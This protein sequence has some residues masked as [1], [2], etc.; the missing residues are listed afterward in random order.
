MDIHSAQLSKGPLH[1]ADIPG[2]LPALVVIHG[3][4]GRPHDFKRLFP[5]IPSQRIIAVALPGMG[6]SPLH[7]P[8]YDI[9]GCASLVGELLEYLELDSVHLLGHSFGAT[10]ATFFTDKHPKKV[11]SLILL[12]SVGHRAHRIFRYSCATSLYPLTQTWGIRRCMSWVLPKLFQ[13][14]GFPKRL[15]YKVITQVLRLSWNFPFQDF[16]Q[17]LSRIN[18]QCLIVHAKDDPIVEYRLAEENQSLIANSRLEILDKGGH[19]P[20]VSNP[21]T[22]GR[23]IKKMLDPN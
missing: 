10:L 4:P 21:E 17:S 11:R 14:L 19:N 5:F 23:W 22:L 13:L 6:I 2:K 15:D 20:Q 9:K 1:Y 7:T 3:F 12:S 18:T 16:H 8:P